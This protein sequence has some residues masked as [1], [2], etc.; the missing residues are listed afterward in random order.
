MRKPVVPRFLLL[1]VLYGLIFV[2]LVQFQFSNKNNFILRTGS[3]VI[4]GNSAGAAERI[5]GLYP[6][7][8][9]V[10]VFF[11]GM[12]FIL[13]NGLELT[14][15]ENVSVYPE[16]MVIM[17][18]EVYFRLNRGPEL[19]FTTQYTGG[20]IELAIRAG[21]SVS[22]S[23]AIEFSDEPDGSLAAITGTEYHSL[24]IPFR[25]LRTSK[26]LEKN[27][28]VL[29]NSD[30]VNYNFNRN[31]GADSVV[32]E[33][34]NPA[35]SYRVLPDRETANPRDFFVPA[36]L[37]NE[38]YEAAVTL[39]L[40]RSYSLWNR[41]V[42]GRETVNGELLCAYLSEAL[43]RGTYRSAA[44]AVSASWTPANS[45]YEAS[46][47]I[48]RLDAAQQNIAAAERE[49]FSRT[50]RLFNE[51]SPEFLKEYR[52][53]DF[54]AVRGYGNL[55]DDAAEILRTFDPAAMTPEQAA[56]FLEGYLDWEYYRPGKRNPYNRFVDQALFVIT[57]HLQKNPRTGGG[58]LVFIKSGS[59]DEE[60]DTELNLRLG[61]A[62]VQYND[63]IKVALGKTLILSALS[64][65]D[66]SGDVPRMARKN[67]TGYGERL[68]SSR[69]YR[70]CFAGENYARAQAAGSGFWAWTAAS[71]ISRNVVSD[72][73]DIT[74]NFPAGETHYM[75]IRGIRPF[76]SLLF[77]NVNANQD[78]LFERY[79][80]SGWVYLPAEQ[81]LLVKFR[82]RLPAERITVIY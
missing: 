73:M 75:I 5:P 4:Q 45:F 82:H 74:V 43:K 36:A 27:N 55:M 59:S 25:P 72:R 2:F 20:S 50:A 62:L 38:E 68:H 11:G 7:S 76:A 26:V 41:A 80:Y 47:Y 37:N 49:R 56:G 42:A 57:E 60:A 29:I 63:E 66:E 48:G 10:S 17:D 16:L 69:I 22:D 21:F 33:V 44:A 12:E 32:L 64:L 52:I 31:T 77:N 71:S 1:L 9:P 8:G 23:S 78:N 58:A 34:H 40:D 79:D 67:F 14:G 30:G 46:S 70:I 18:D 51:R 65:A 35:V 39:W 81:T 53:I 3:M 15:F 19:V 24:K 13:G 6:L 54:L 61:S 28:A